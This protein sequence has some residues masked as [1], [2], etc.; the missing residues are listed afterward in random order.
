MV[1]TALLGAACSSS[2]AAV[3][4]TATTAAA[5]HPAVTPKAKKPKGN[6]PGTYSN[7]SS[8]TGNTGSPITLPGGGTVP[9]V[10]PSAAST[11]TTAADSGASSGATVTKP[12]F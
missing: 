1:C 11:T 3:K 6:I 5:V 8:V 10:N 4:K 2:S 9:G 7:G 12:T